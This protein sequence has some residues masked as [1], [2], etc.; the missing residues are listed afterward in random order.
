M[1]SSVQGGPGQFDP[2]LLPQYLE[3]NSAIERFTADMV[4]HDP[5]AFGRGR[6][7]IRYVVERQLYFGLVAD[8]KLY[9]YF[10]AC[11]TGSELPDDGELPFLARF[12]AP[13][14]RK[15]RPDF[16]AVLDRK[17]RILRYLYRL[18]GRASIRLD[19]CGADSPQ[20]LFLVIHPKFVRYLGPI[21]EKLA[22]PYA[23][24]A[25]D[26]PATF[27]ALREQN[28]PRMHMEMTAESLNMTV[29]EVEIFH[30]KF[31]PGFFE[32]WIIRLN[33]VRR[34]LKLLQPRCIVVPEGNAAIY[35]LVNQSTKTIQIPTL[36]VQQGWAPVVHPGFRNMSYARMCVWGD[37]FAE[38]LAPYNSE[39]RFVVT[40]NHVIDCQP[41]G[42]VGK[43]HAVA[44]FL[45]NGAYWLTE[46][47]E[48]E[49]LQLIVWAAEAFPD[50]EI[51]VREHPG[52]QL[53]AADS[54]RLAEVKNVRLMPP[55][56][57]SLKD[58]LAECRVALA[59]S[60][61]TILE[62]LASGVV[63]LILN[64]VGFGTYSPDIAAAGAAIEVGDFGA[65]RIALGNLMADDRFAA[66]FGSPFGEVRPRLFAR[67]GDQAL[68]AIVAE[69]RQTAGLDAVR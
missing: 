47:A 34:A 18:H 6:S 66:S 67:N 52:T 13:Y 29:P 15:A 11:E 7:S 41:Q 33:A 58:V 68:N 39:Q 4:A 54:M 26:D 55:A 35:E 22:V 27:D 10:V 37:E 5:A 42:E 30:E 16:G 43:R 2:F 61:T 40:G 23:F 9:N 38:M 3:L 32:A 1:N 8:R 14:F 65:A 49:M 51:R 60:S 46:T 21:V 25:I 19:G 62:A 59:I 57:Y 20:V 36:C 48:R 31:R 63:P 17:S 28:L 69:I 45:Q 12:I 44:F 64:V 53:A 50:R 56:E 24:L